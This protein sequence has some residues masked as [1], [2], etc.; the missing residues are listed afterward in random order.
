MES[1]R[2]SEVSQSPATAA[3]SSTFKRGFQAFPPGQ[4]RSAENE[5]ATHDVASPRFRQEGG[6]ADK[7]A[8][9]QAQEPCFLFPLLPPPPAETLPSQPSSQLVCAKGRVKLK[10]KGVRALEVARDA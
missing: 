5:R 10:R 6:H 1:P 8:C 4:A 3:H 2:G 9:Q 7:M